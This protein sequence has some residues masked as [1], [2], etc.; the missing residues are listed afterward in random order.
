MDGWM[1]GWMDGAELPKLDH[2]TITFIYFLWSFYTFL[3]K[4]SLENCLRDK[5]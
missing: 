4:K 2:S 1:D 5:I 3:E